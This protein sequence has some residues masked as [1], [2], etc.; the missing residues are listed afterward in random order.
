MCMNIS[1][2][3]KNEP[4]IETLVEYTGFV[5]FEVLEEVYERDEMICIYFFHTY[6]YI[7]IS[8]I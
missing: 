5:D 6:I 1:K 2:D 4:P 8:F 7:Y 3:Q